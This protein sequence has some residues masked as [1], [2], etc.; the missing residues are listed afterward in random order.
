MLCNSRVRAGRSSDAGTMPAPRSRRRAAKTAAP[1]STIGNAPDTVNGTMRLSAYGAERAAK[2][3]GVS[4]ANH[5]SRVNY[6]RSSASPGQ[7]PELR[8]LALWH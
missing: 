1:V 8:L 7:R 5:A 3:N 6:R 4:Q 2:P